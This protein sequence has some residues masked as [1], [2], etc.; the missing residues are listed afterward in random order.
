MEIL[1]LAPSDSYALLD[2]GNGRKL[3]RFGSYITSRP[4][5]NAIW[6]PR[7]P[8]SAWKEAH[9]TFRTDVPRGEKRWA[10]RG[11]DERA[12]WQI[13]FEGLTLNLKPTPF[14][15]TGLFPEQA[16]NWRWFGKLIEKSPSPVKVLNLFGYTGGATLYAA[17]CGAQVTH[18]DASKP[19]V[20]WA[21]D[22]QASSGLDDKPI[23][24]IIDDAVKFAA[25]EVKRGNTYDAVIMDPPSFGRDPQGK[26]FK[27]EEDVPRLLETVKQ[28]APD[29]LFILINSY[30]L[31][32]SPEVIRNML[33]DILPLSSVA[34]GELHIE[35]DMRS[36]PL[37]GC[38]PESAGNPRCAGR[39]LPCSI[40]A[41]YEKR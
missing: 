27:F 38:S 29:P 8:L 34:C 33:G 22:N 2:S 32:F 21:R 31:G 15:H 13:D 36:R 6:K 10:L 25:R 39:H 11:F 16:S 26:V 19:A 20:T 3:E 28:L 37:E 17:R 41:R 1:T 18:V 7:L 14:K 23:R 40:F 5:P 9:A 12:P 24:W 35:E 4:D 30:S